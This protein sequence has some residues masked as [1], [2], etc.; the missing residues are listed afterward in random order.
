MSILDSL[1]NTAH[2]FDVLGRSIEVIQN[3]VANASTPGFTRQKLPLYARPFEAGVLPGGVAAGGLQST[4][5]QYAERGVRYQ[6]EILGTLQERKA[7]LQG[8]EQV[9]DAS[10]KTGIGASMAKL[11]GSFSAWSVAPNDRNAR[12][13]VLRSSQRLA[14]DFQ[15][16]AAGITE[17]AVA[18]E[19]QTRQVVDRI[20][21]LVGTIR[22]LNQAR[23]NL[24]SGD[25]GLEA[26]A[27]NAL[28]SLADLVNVNAVTQQDGTISVSLAGQFPLLVGDFQTELSVTFEHP[29]APIYPDTL[30]GAHLWA[31][32]VE[33]TDTVARGRLSALLEFRNQTVPS[34]IGGYDQ[35][36]KLNQ[37]AIA[38]A[39]RVNDISPQAGGLFAYDPGSAA[40]SIK[41]TPGLTAD[42]LIAS[43]T[44][45]NDVPLALARLADFTSPADGVGG[46][47]YSEFFA[48]AV[49]RVGAELFDAAESADVQAGVLAQARSIRAR[50]SG[51]SF[52]EEA[53]SLME[54]QRAYEATARM[55]TVLNEMTQTIV[56]LLR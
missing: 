39:D 17:Q 52:D 50:L 26:R 16:T 47:S 32:N 49:G 12:E 30:P 19:A 31:G 24:N 28:E 20:N 45:A 43:D 37:L 36:G 9:F 35:L 11:F 13:D 3:N 25:P 48:G 18:A 40:S 29:P 22:Q 5:D 27:Y 33:L 15:K 46:L 21:G 54:F 10:G 34:L 53:L 6:A 8:L 23:Q 55:T 7:A 14:D 41:V 38:F 2:T 51:V 1:R 44:T 4:R 56:N 42:G